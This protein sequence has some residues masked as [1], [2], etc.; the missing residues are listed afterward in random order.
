MR[1]LI[2][3]VLCASPALADQ[4][5]L[6]L[7]TAAPDG[8][9][10]ARQ[11]KFTG[12]GI[13]Q[14]TKGALHVKWFFGGI[15]GDEMEAADRM[16]KGQLDGIASGGPLCERI[17]PTMRVLGMPGLFQSREEA[18]Y[19]MHVLRPEITDEAQRSG[20]A[21]LITSGLG[22]SVVF[23]RQPIRNLSDLRSARLWT[24][25]LDEVESTAARTMGLKVVPDSLQAAGKL[26]SNNAIDGFIAVPGAALAFQWSIQAKYFTNLRLGYLTACI[27]ISNR[28]FDKL[29]VEQQNILRG[30]FA[31]ADARFEEF[32]R[33][34]D[35]DLLGGLFQKQGLIS[36]PASETFRSQFFDAARQ[37]REKLGGLVPQ[38]LIARVLQLLVDYRAEHDSARAK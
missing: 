37:S 1:T 2:F 5:T 4:G 15:A 16:S 25:G 11:L 20:F 10:W 12:D 26:Y 14:A 34:M 18:A 36:V 19:V 23:S 29:P 22:P 33:R 35:D 17:A 38:P 3:L 30:E 7:A 9:A 8:T 21:V 6:R 28:I 32:G 31:R 27:V 24:W 13:G